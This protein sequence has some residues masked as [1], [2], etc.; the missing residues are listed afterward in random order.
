LVLPNRNDVDT[1]WS[2]VRSSARKVAAMAAMPVLKQA[3]GDA[4]LHLR[5]LRLQRSRRGDCPGARRHNRAFVLEDLHEVARVGDSRTPPPCASACGRNSARSANRVGMQDRGGESV[6]WT[7]YAH[8]RL[9]G[10]SPSFLSGRKKTR[11]AFA[12]PGSRLALAVFVTRPQA[13][14]KSARREITPTDR[15]CKQERAPSPPTV[16]TPGRAGASLLD[17]PSSR[18]RAASPHAVQVRL[19]TSP[20]M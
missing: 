16:S 12:G 13:D 4:P 19:V 17:R 6:L 5:D 7:P 3:G 8:P 11:S 18:R 20:V 10:T 2:P 14:L 1:T 9:Q 15:L